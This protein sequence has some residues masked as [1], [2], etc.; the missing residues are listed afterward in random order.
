MNVRVFLQVLAK[1]K[2][3]EADDTDKLFCWLMGGHVSPKGESSGEFLVTVVIFAFKG[4]FHSYVSYVVIFMEVFSFT[5]IIKFFIIELCL[6]IQFC[7]LSDLLFNL[8][9][10]S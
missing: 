2:F 7:R 9:N 3:L 6:N 1:S 4:S 8:R 5:G 10:F